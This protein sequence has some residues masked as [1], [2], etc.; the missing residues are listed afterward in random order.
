ML[1]LSR[2]ESRTA[3][4][5]APQV[6]QAKGSPVCC[7]LRQH[8]PAWPGSPASWGPGQ[9]WPRTQTAG[10]SP[11]KSPRVPRKRAAL[12]GCHQ[13][14]LPGLKLMGDFLYCGGNRRYPCHLYNIPGRTSRREDRGGKEPGQ[15]L[16]PWRTFGSGSSRGIHRGRGLAGS[17]HMVRA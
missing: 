14:R 16:A 9:G 1:P 7:M 3:Q 6:S 17:R 15:G 4:G 12:R 13:F 8:R 10:P 2:N 11:L 5:S